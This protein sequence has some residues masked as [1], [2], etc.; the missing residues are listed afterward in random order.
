M[1]REGAGPCRKWP[2]IDFPKIAADACSEQLWGGK[3]EI[4]LGAGRV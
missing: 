2:Q 1:F 3:R 4:F